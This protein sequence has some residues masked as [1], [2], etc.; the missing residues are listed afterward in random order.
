METTWIVVANGEHARFF[1]RVGWGEDWEHLFDREP[2]ARAALE[3]GASV[4]EE[5]AEHF[6]HQLAD[7][8]ARNLEGYERLVIAAPAHFLRRLHTAL[9]PQV[10]ERLD[11]TLD[12]DRVLGRAP[13]SDGR[14][15]LA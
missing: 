9:A 3:G 14:L 2:Q 1:Q 7:M 10:A 8:L 11:A 4:P 12:T 6:A 5:E 13:Y 15:D